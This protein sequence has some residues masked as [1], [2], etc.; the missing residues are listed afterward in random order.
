MNS[1]FD[2]KESFPAQ[3]KWALTNNSH[4]FLLG[5]N[6]F[7][8]LELKLVDSSNSSNE[9]NAS[10]LPQRRYLRKVQV[11]VPGRFNKLNSPVTR[12][13]HARSK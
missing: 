9:A 10:V 6:V 8:T 11:S 2:K 7:H 4:R 3:V 12:S 1:L 13:K 5:S